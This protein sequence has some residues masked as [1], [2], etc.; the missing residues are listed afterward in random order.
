MVLSLTL[1]FIILYSEWIKH[2][3]GLALYVHAVKTFLGAEL[4]REENII[5]SKGSESFGATDTCLINRKGDT[6]STSRKKKETWIAI[7][8]YAYH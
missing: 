4:L 6:Y 3:K 7:N 5:L 8:I 1:E 2:K